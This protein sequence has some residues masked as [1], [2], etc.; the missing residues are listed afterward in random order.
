MLMWFLIL[1]WILWT[2]RRLT[3]PT[4]TLSQ[5]KTCSQVHVGTTPSCTLSL[6]FPGSLKTMEGYSFSKSVVK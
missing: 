6:L 5:D 4:S 2:R 1:R 3:S